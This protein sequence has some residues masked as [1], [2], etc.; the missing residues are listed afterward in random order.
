M[1]TKRQEES[2]CQPQQP[3]GQLDPISDA[4]DD[5]LEVVSTSRKDESMSS[6]DAV[7]EKIQ[8]LT[9]ARQNE[10]KRKEEHLRVQL[11]MEDQTKGKLTFLA[12]AL[13]T[14][15]A[16]RLTNVVNED[17]VVATIATVNAFSGGVG[18]GT[19]GAAAST[20]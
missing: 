17:D 18:G 16:V 9:K 20:K 5:G 13:A 4:D 1:P 6:N 2:D 14:T 10:A 8:V 12:A 11:E 19:G 15:A 3:T 7:H